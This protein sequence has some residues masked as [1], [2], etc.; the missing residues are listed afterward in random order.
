MKCFLPANWTTDATTNKQYIVGNTSTLNLTESTKTCGH[1]NAIL[2]EPQNEQENKF[3]GSLNAGVFQLGLTG[4]AILPSGSVWRWISNNDLVQRYFWAPGEPSE[5]PE[6]CVV[7]VKRHNIDSWD[8]VKC[9]N[10][11]V[12]ISLVCQKR[13]GK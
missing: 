13:E 3:L 10:R 2:P 7:M 4:K 5:P 11:T 6:A 9:R 12:P 1:Y 8:D